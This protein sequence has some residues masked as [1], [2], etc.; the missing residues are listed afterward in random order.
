MFR[1]DTASIAAIFQCIRDDTCE[2]MLCN[3]HWYFDDD[4]ANSMHLVALT[5]CSLPNAAHQNH[6]TASF[7]CYVCVWQPFVEFCFKIDIKCHPK[8]VKSGEN[9]MILT[10]TQ[11]Q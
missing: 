1:T 9:K 7:D 5:F 8:A 4:T 2:Y 11:M 10:L 3:L 6:K